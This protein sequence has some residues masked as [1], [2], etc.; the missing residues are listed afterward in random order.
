[1]QSDPSTFTALLT[2]WRSGDQEAGNRLFAAAS[3]ELR[4]LAAWHFKHERPSHTLQPT[5]LVN[6][7]YV[8]LFAGAPIYWQN[9]AHFFAVAAQQMRRLL[10]DHARARLA[11]K[12][13]VTQIR[14][15][16]SDV[17]G[18]AGSNDGQEPEIQDLHFP[19]RRQLNVGRLQ[20]TMDDSLFMRRF[21]RF[22][23]LP[24]NVQRFLD[25]NRTATKPI[26]ERLAF[27]N[28]SRARKTTPMPPSPSGDV[29]SYGPMR[30]PAVRDILRP[31]YSRHR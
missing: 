23:N 8:K 24:R 17:Q 20:V 30:I 1:M 22:A 27:H 10:I 14:L 9:R 2:A 6:E 25:R 11:N 26:V 3:Y 15:P 13:G 28:T 5:A 16:L 31:D 4:R 18:I 21:Q 12:R 19:I 7:L 29:T